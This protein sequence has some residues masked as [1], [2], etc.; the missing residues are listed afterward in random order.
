MVEA[1]T[2]N[3]AVLGSFAV[4][5]KGKLLAASVVGGSRAAGGRRRVS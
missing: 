5:L 3:L 4:A 1:T 2:H